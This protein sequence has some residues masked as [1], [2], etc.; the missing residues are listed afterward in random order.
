MG[1]KSVGVFIKNTVNKIGFWSKKN[2]PEILIVTGVV[3][4]AGA[5]G[6]AIYSTTKLNKVT[7]P[8]KE[9]VKLIHKKMEDEYIK[10]LDNEEYVSQYDGKKELT[11]AYAHGA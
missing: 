11:K 2:S 1:L 10:E 3:L 4:A 5:V 9:K 6:S 8:L 7:K